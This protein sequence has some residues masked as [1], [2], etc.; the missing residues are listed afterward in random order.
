MAAQSREE[1]RH[2]ERHRYA[3]GRW[4]EESESETDWEDDRRWRE[5]RGTG[6]GGSES[7]E[8]AEG[9]RRRGQQQAD[10]ERPRMI[11]DMGARWIQA[12]RAPR[13]PSKERYRGHRLYIQNFPFVWRNHCPG[14]Q[15]RGRTRDK[16]YTLFNEAGV[17]CYDVYMA[18]PH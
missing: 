6:P 17:P 10:G 11:L 8:A 18:H 5:W 1:E 15:S 12:G 2:P 14:G 3:A 13:V 9:P 7:E 16:M 4:R